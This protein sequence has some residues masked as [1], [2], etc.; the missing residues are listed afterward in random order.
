M[1]KKEGFDNIAQISRERIH[2][3]GEHLAEQRKNLLGNDSEIFDIGFRSFALS[4]TFIEK[5]QIDNQ[6]DQSK[7]EQHLF[8]LRE[9]AEDSANAL[10]LVFEILLK[11][12]FSLTESVEPVTISGLNLISIGGGLVFAYVDEVTKPSLQA[13]RAALDLHPAKLIVLEDALQGDDELKT[14]LLQLCTSQNIE[15]WTV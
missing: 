5:W 4:N 6:V 2:R 8:A 1:A 9:N 7:L 10:D 15:L 12:G 13:V 3:A 14:N 11:Q